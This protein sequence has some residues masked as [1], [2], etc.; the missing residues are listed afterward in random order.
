MKIGYFV[1]HYPYEEEYDDYFSGGVGNVASNLANE[2]ARLGHDIYIFTTS[3]T[4]KSSF[5]EVNG[6]KIFRYGSYFK[7]ANCYISLKLLW[8]PLNHKLDLLHAHMGNA[9]APYSALIYSKLRGTP[10]IT[11]YHGDQQDGYGSFLR[12]FSVFVHNKIFAGYILK[13]SKLIITP[14]LPF[15]NES[16]FLKYFKDKITMIPNGIDMN[17]IDNSKGKEEYRREL[18][19]PENDT[20]FL[21]VGA[22]AKYKGPEILLKAIKLVALQNP[23]CLFIYIGDGQMMDEL[24]SLSKE[25]E[26]TDKV[27]FLGFVDEDSKWKYYSAADIFVLPSTMNTEVFPIVLLEASASRLPLVVSDLDTFKC[28]ITEGTNGFFT[29]RNDPSDLAGCLLKLMNNKSLVNTTA[30]NAYI[31][32]KKYSWVKIAKKVD[33]LYF[34]LHR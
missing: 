25:L 5:Q 21:F 29:K 7:I 32:A 31:V 28:I 16:K 27:N 1:T 9:P 15:I 4:S 2:M 19:L 23:N 20:I 26:I 12:R 22:L 24:K 8:G 13:N 18:H 10:L 3:R 33:D 34:N 11:T 30:N 14:S 6:I 17:A